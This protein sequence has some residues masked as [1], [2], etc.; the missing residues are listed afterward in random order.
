VLQACSKNLESIKNLIGYSREASPAYI[1]VY[2]AYGIKVK[3]YQL[4]F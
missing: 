1:K 3:G 4:G 2:G